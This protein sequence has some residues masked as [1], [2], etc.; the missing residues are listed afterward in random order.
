MLS[1]RNSH[2]P[3]QF[4]AMDSASLG[5]LN[6][7]SC[8]EGATWRSKKA[9]PTLPRACPPPHPR[10]GWGV[11]GGMEG[12]GGPHIAKN[13]NPGIDYDPHDDQAIASAC[14]SGNHCD[15]STRPVSRT[16][17]NCTAWSTCDTKYCDSAANASTMSRKQTSSQRLLIRCVS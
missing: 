8:A 15:S 14:S 6:P 4:E 1:A 16:G 5:A 3:L 9:W 7:L 17:T 2:L 11:V 12:G 13:S 10:K